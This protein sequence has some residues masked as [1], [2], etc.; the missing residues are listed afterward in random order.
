MKSERMNEVRQ[1][2]ATRQWVI[3][4]TA[5]GKR[6][7]DFQEATEGNQKLSA[8]DHGCP[9]CPGNERMLPS[10][11][12]E[13]IGNEPK[14]WQTRVV[15]NKFPALTPE[16]D[17]IRLP[18]GLYV[19]MGGYGRHE[20]IVESPRHDQDIALMSPREVDTV[21]ETYHKRFC[22][23]IDNCKNMMIIIFRNHGLKAGTSLIHPHSQMIVTGFVPNYIRWREEEAQRYFDEW[24]R[25]VY[26]DILEFETK[27]RQRVILENESFL[28]FVPYAAEVPFETWVMPKKHL[29]SFGRI[30]DPSK[31]DLAVALHDILTKLRLKLGDPDYN[32]IINTSTQ[33]KTDEPQLHWYLQIRP[34]LTTQAGFEIG[35]GISINPSLPEEDA[36]FLRM[37]R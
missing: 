23:L 25:C 22:D 26:C 16:G 32:Y 37:E 28:V 3:Y 30:S 17:V 11:I 36:D 14:E 24:G 4:A 29:T 18:Q 1:N 27:D 33:Y 12:L 13:M 15:P 7:R 8:F 2:K 21:I 19:A 5:R 9:F 35:S 20:V 34:R 10:I 6:P 31:A